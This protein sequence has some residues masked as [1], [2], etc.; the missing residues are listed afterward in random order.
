MVWDV[1]VADSLAPSYIPLTSVAAGEAA[2][3][4]ASLKVRKYSNLSSSYLFTPLAFESLGPPDPDCADFLKALGTRTS[5]ITGD[6]REPSYLWQRLSMAIQ[7]HNAAGIL[8]HLGSCLPGPSQTSP[9]SPRLPCLGAPARD[10]DTSS[11]LTASFASSD[12]YGRKIRLSEVV[13][14]SKSRSR[15][16]SRRRHRDSR[17]RSGS[18]SRS[19]RRSRSGDR[20]SRGKEDRDSRSR[21]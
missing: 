16:R 17:S 12:I 11:V 4:A 13:E 18:R 1:T 5:A 20:R 3:R 14:K 8:T 7:R 9:T 21:L 2:V 6:K 15:S 19:E 10:P